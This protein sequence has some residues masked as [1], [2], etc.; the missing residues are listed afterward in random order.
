M[1]KVPHFLLLL[2]PCRKNWLVFI[3]LFK[4]YFLKYS[5]QQRGCRCP[6]MSQGQKYQNE[7]G[8]LT[9]V[10]WNSKCPYPQLPLSGLSSQLRY[11]LGQTSFIS[12]ISSSVTSVTPCTQQ[13]L[14]AYCKH[15]GADSLSPHHVC[16]LVTT[17][18]VSSPWVQARPIALV[19]MNKTMTS[20][21]GFCF[22]DLMA[23]GDWDFYL[24]C[25][26]S[27]SHCSFLGKPAAQ[28]DLFYEKT[29]EVRK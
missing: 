10:N 8:L 29:P 6:N 3:S 23:K 21:V 28:K 27:W 13:Q 1:R 26:L 9:G 17:Y 16:L 15:A 22:W 18:M 4:K 11:T 5:V 25:C 24:P 7:S 2:L 19:L 12:W 20:G 14:D